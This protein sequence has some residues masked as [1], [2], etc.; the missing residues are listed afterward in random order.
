[1]KAN[2]NEFFETYSEKAMLGEYIEFLL[3]K[4]QILPSDILGEG[5]LI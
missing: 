4:G 1:M 3:K 5:G 2:F